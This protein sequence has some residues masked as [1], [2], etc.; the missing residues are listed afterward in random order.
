MA[1]KNNTKKAFSS[2]EDDN[3]LDLL[4]VA[5]YFLN[6]WYLF[7]VFFL[8]GA[9]AFGY[10]A[11]MNPYTYTSTASIFI[12]SETTSITS[13]ADIQLGNAL[14]GDFVELAT[15]KPV[16]DTAI[17][18]IEDE[19]GIT[20]T[21]EQVKGSTSIRN[22]E[23][24]RLLIFSATSYDPVLS[25]CIAQSMAEATAEQVSLIM[26]ADKPTIVE[27][28]ELEGPNGKGMKRKALIGGVAGACI[29]GV[30]LLILYLLNDKIVDEEDVRKYL[31][32]NVIGVISVDKA[33]SYKRNKKKKRR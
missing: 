15:C 11:V 5:K 9:L 25:K 2:L 7:L 29:P 21:R 12:Q 14:S 33:A 16:L 26:K 10:R 8:I 31:G 17:G 18:Y 4:D 32:S 22:K 19:L 3:E 13:M 24:T 28:A 6:Y 23:D 20:L 27:R 1:L 30:I